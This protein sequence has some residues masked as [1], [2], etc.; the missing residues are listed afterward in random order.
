MGRK[1]RFQ[2]HLLLLS[3]Y[4]VLKSVSLIRTVGIAQLPIN[5]LFWQQTSFFCNGELIESRFKRINSWVIITSKL[6]ASNKLTTSLKISPTFSKH[7]KASQGGGFARNL[8]VP[9]RLPTLKNV[10]PLFDKPP[11]SLQLFTSI[12]HELCTHRILSALQ[13]LLQAFLIIISYASVGKRHVETQ[14]LSSAPTAESTFL[15]HSF[16]WGLLTDYVRYWM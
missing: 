14:E 4:A 16:S 3:L 8:S 5:W 11:R 6:I 2:K 7:I 1:R 13:T 12:S 9:R 10:Y 15:W